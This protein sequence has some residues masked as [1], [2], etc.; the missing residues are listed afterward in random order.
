MGSIWRAD[1]TLL[2]RSVA[3]KEVDIPAHLPDD[4]QDALRARVMREARAA[5]RLSHPGAVTVFDVVEEDGRPFIVMELLDAPTLK[6]VVA[7]DGPLAPQAAAELG[8]QVLD[9]LDAAHRAGIVHR[10]VK[11]SN[12]MVPANGRVKLTDFGIASLRDDPR[13]TATG[14]VVG[15][16]SYMAPEQARFARTEPASDLWSLGATLW[17]AVE[18]TSPFDRGDAIATLTAVVHDDPPPPARADALGPVLQALLAKEPAE[19][20]TVA[21]TRQLLSNV[22]A[23]PTTAVPTTAVPTTASPPTPAVEPPVPRRTSAPSPLPARPR[24]GSWLVALLAAMA[25]VL[26]VVV[27]VLVIRRS[28]G[29]GTPSTSTSTTATAPTPGRGAAANGP[30]ARG[31]YRDATIG[32]SIDYPAGWQVV[33]RAGSNI[34]DIRD[35]RSGAYLRVDWVT[36]PNGSPVTAWQQFEPTFAAQNGGYHRVAITPTTFR[37]QPA[38]SWEYTYTAG[39]ATL[40]AVDLGFVT[41]RY[42][43]ALNFQ[44]RDRDWAA[45]QPTFSA[46]QRWFQP[47]A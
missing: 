38:A 45:M 21:A 40:H 16:P 15:S 25:V 23:A 46:F 4:E 34:T 32:W 43:F 12:V 47:P 9:A 41:G 2:Q 3:V 5:A 33:R 1:D 20:P 29:G 27:V 11:P 39:G 30:A 26:A 17:Y 6:D 7:T 28:G 22:A 10:D 44:T 18:G 24:A 13:I 14:L 19:R 35:P 42:G 8:L 36:P 31:H 37:G